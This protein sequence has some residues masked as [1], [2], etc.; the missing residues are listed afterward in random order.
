MRAQSNLERGQRGVLRKL[1]QHSEILKVGWTFNQINA[2][3][4]KIIPNFAEMMA[5]SVSSSATERM[6]TGR[7]RE[8][9]LEIVNQLL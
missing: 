2:R 7:P 1:L 4:P 5:G 6:E 3:N 8:G 9:L